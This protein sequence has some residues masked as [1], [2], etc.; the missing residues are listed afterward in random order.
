MSEADALAELAERIQQ[1]A[2]A[3]GFAECAI[4]DLDLDDHVARL[5]KWLDEERHGDMSY[6]ERHLHIRADL[7]HLLPGARRAIV[8]RLDHL[9]ADTRPIK[10]LGQPNTAYISRYA[11]G[12]DYHKLMRKR[13]AQLADFINAEPQVQDA[14]FRACVDSAPVLEKALAERAGIGWFGKNTLILNRHAGSWFF[15][16]ELLTDLPLPISPPQAS[17]HCGSCSACIDICPTQ[18]I[19]GPRE[20]DATR[21]I[22]YLTIEHKGVIPE[23]LRSAMGNRVFGCDD[24]QLCCPWN[25][26]AQPT[27][28]A[29]FQ[30]RHG[31]DAAELLTLFAWNETEFLNRTAGSAIRRISHEQWQRNLAIGLGNAPKSPRIAAALTA[32][33]PTAGSVLLPHLDWALAQQQARD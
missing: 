14:G 27:A 18:A 1:Q 32:A 6:L 17:E 5:R 7:T 24:C 29:D 19:T 2:T 11:L 4:T 23:A 16:G 31:L 22:S 21:C 28:E 10:I 26:Y 12:R 20:L 13:L 33:R 30:P 25:R 9:P 8:V 15:L 3:L